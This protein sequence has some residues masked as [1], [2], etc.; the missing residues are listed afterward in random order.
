[1]CEGPADRDDPAVPIVSSAALAP[2]MLSGVV[3]LGPVLRAPDAP[4]RSAA[5]SA[6]PKRCVGAAQV[7]AAQRYA[8]SRPGNVSFA[9]VERGEVRSF[10]GGV[11][12]RSASLVKAMLLIADLRRHARMGAPL[13]AAARG[14]LAAMIRISDNGAASATFDLVGAGGLRSVARLAGMRSYTV[15]GYWG[16]SQLTA[17]DQA[18]LFARIDQVLPKR[19]RRYGRSLLRTIIPAQT[20]GGAPVARRHGFNTVFKA[21]WLPRSDGWVVHQGLR[22]ERGR[23]TLGVAVLTGA[24]PGMAA[25]V[26][27]IRGV[28]ERLL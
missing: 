19:Y 14:R 26:E 13:D 2:L 10:G 15:G 22:V 11:P 24:Q 17:A 23:C 20:W 3:A 8:A 28:V 25:G 18:R 12:Y 9:V 7:A 5:V 1:M 21:G 4:P 6:Q 27:S 16:T